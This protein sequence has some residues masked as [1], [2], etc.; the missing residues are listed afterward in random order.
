MKRLQVVVLWG[1][2]VWLGMAGRVYA[3]PDQGAFVKH[4]PQTNTLILG[5]EFV[6]LHFRPY[7]VR[8]VN[9]LAKH[10]VPVE[11]D[12]FSLGIEGRQPLHAADFKFQKAV[13]ESVTGGQQLVLRLDCP[14]P[15]VA[16]EIRYCL[17]DQDPFVRR[18]LEARVSQPLALR[19]V[20]AWVVKVP[21]ACSHQGFGEPVFLEDTFWG[22]EFPAAQ[23]RHADGTVRL[24]HFPGRTVPDR[25]ASKPAVLGVAEP[26][27]VARRFRQYIETIQDPGNRM[28]LFVNY[29]TWWTLM[30]PTEENCLALIDVFKKNL[31]DPHGESIDT[32]TIDD[33][34][35]NKDSLWAIRSDR[36][37]RGFAPLVDSLKSINSQLGLWLSPSS[38]Y[39]HAPWG[40]KNGYEQNSNPWFLCQSGPHYRRDIVKVVTGLAEK[41]KLAFFKFDGF[42][43]TCEAEGH[44]HLPGPYAQEANV[45]A[46][47]EL[48]QAVRRVRSDIYLDPTC[49]I[50]LSPWWLAYANSLWGSV[51]GDYP[52][53]IVPAPIIRD[54]ATTTR[55]GV[56]RQRC[57][58]HPGFPPSA[59][60]HLGIIVITPEKWEDNAMIVVGRG[61]R[62]LTLY[63]NPKFFTKPHRDW[64][65][66][67]ALL[68]W[69]RHNG[70]ALQ[71]TELILGD[72]MKREPYGYAHFGGRR[73]ILALRNPFIEPRKIAVKLDES[74]GWSPCDAAAAKAEGGYVAQIVYPRHET[75]PRLFRYG[76]ALEVVLNAYETMLVHLDPV[77][78]PQPALLGLRSREL[79]R[80]GN[81]VRYAVYG[82][83]GQK[84]D[85]VLA[86]PTRPEKASFDGRPLD[87]AENQGQTV[88]PMAFSGQ[89]EACTV[90]GATLA[91]EPG[92][93]ELQWRGR[94]TVTVPAA[95]K[96]TM[97]LLC[98]PRNPAPAKLQCA[99]RLSGQPV[100]V[101]AVRAPNQS[102]Q[103]H[104]KHP[105]VWFAFDVPA[106]RSEVEL[107]ITPE[108]GAMFRGELGWWLWA[109]HPLKESTLTL[110]F[111]EPLPE[112]PNDP[113]PLPIDIAFH[114][115]VI[116]IVPPKLFRTG[117][118]WP[119][120]DQTQ[121]RLETV[122]PDECEQQWGTLVKNQ[123]VW[124]KEMIVAGRKFTR[125]LGTHADSRLAYDLVGGGFK[126]FRCLVGRDEHAGDGRVE[127]EVWLDGK[128]AFASGPMTK[129]SPAKPV[130]ID[131]AG[132]ALLEL[133]TL[134]GGD[135]ISGDHGDWAEPELVR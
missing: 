2:L 12:D 3:Q 78:G 27:R 110:Q 124:E 1:P 10:I 107:T 83:P 18:H 126:K 6:E 105:W 26:G 37:P 50:W 63:I 43:A 69:V 28:P 67:A 122:E 15:S 8:I 17:G 135:G 46:F 64:A 71:Q 5:N 92:T 31:F 42:S 121:V 116:P 49:G 60:E 39:N 77:G 23:N 114:R 108:S 90:T 4:D 117:Q 21:G 79:Q 88:L 113:L 11:A 44:G 98:D 48:M 20:E 51:S 133:R 35:D 99:A 22:L 89:A 106:G 72:P 109:E 24:T 120:A 95:T 73:G 102:D 130:E 82:A 80:T 128:R 53:I 30:P 34:W 58:E 129:S 125:G 59:I 55:D 70:P 81:E 66:L 118:R 100:E 119:K 45:D 52:D 32:F 40:G 38:G 123:S 96:A 94:C 101:R 68:K 9:K 65:F 104:G 84:A 85:A 36:F 127:F 7:L 97:Y 131:V 54:S 111:K 74:A 16:L 13:S 29:N 33:G 41:Y 61:C 134:D 57:R 112:P 115:E 14:Q 86:G 87:L 62:L 91:A 56:F 19:T 132:A 76:D 25:F 75:L 93:A 47:I 103:A